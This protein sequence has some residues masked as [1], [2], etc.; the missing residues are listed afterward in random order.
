MLPAGVHE[1]R[2]EG[3]GSRG[4]RLA[5]GIYFVHGVSAEGEFTKTIAI[6]K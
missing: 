1:A 5:S 3:R 6:L 2:I 4:E